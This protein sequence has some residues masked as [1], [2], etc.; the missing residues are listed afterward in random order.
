MDQWHSTPAVAAGIGAIFS[1][2]PRLY[3]AVLYTQLFFAFMFLPAVDPKKEGWRRV[4]IATT[5][6]ILP[7]LIISLHGG[8]FFLAQ[9]VIP[10]IL[11]SIARGWTSISVRRTLQ[12]AALALFI[13]FVP[14]LTRGAGLSDFLD[15]GELIKFFQAGSSLQRFQDNTDLSLEGRCPPFLV[16][17]TA[18]SIPYGLI[19]ICVVDAG[20]LKNLPATLDRIL[21]INDPS[22][23]NGT[24]S[25]S[26]SN[27]LLDLYL[28]GGVPAVFVGSALL[29]SA[30]DDLWDGSGNVHSFREY[31]RN[32]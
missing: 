19:G 15:Q 6:V 3:Q 2:I 28:F 30:A 4:W 20:G 10:A 29:D 11:I 26:G 16:S 1:P 24:M 7:R 23:L 13:I 21:T 27:Y 32:A 31:G 18:K 9:A 8:R 5:L 17:L 22:T 25:G 12:F 14:A